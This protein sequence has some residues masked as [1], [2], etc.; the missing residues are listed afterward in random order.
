MNR[1]RRL[2]VAKQV[3]LSL[4]QQ[5]YIPPA[6]DPIPV[7]GAPGRA[8]L[9]HMAYV[10]EEGH[11]ASAY[12]RALANRLAYVLTGGDVPSLTQVDD[13][14]LLALEREHFLPLIDEPKTKDRILHMLKTKKPLRN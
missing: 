5:G 6:R 3:T 1:D 4:A 2:Y 9:E 12:D 10:M 8:V 13:A 14:H 7:L 11:F